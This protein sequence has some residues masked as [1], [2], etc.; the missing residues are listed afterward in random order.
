[1]SIGTENHIVLHVSCSVIVFIC[2]HLI[3]FVFIELQI[4]VNS[5]ISNY[6]FKQMRFFFVFFCALIIDFT[7]NCMLIY[8]HHSRK[9]ECFAKISHITQPQYYRENKQKICSVFSFIFAQIQ[10]SSEFDLGWKKKFE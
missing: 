8:L 4:R 2:S 1:M 3:L 6:Y 10:Q 7:F 5:F 9:S